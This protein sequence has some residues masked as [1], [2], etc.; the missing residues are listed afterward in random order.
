[1]ESYKEHIQK[2]KEVGVRKLAE[3][4]PQDV[5]YAD[6]FAIGQSIYFAIAEKL[7]IKTIYLSE[8]L[9]SHG[10]LTE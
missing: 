3:N 6:N 7:K 4:Y 9:Y 8:L 2:L 1:M 10:L 5:V